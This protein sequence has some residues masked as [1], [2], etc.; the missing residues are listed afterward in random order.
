M[1][2][3]IKMFAYSPKSQLWTYV[4][5]VPAQ[6]TPDAAVV[7]PGT[8]EM[9]LVTRLRSENY[10]DGLISTVMKAKLRGKG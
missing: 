9:V 1:A 10:R 2:S 8:G 7:I 4:E 5:D 6:N 3:Y